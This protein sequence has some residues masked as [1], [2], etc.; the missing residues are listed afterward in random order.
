MRKFAK[1]LLG[2]A[3]LVGTMSSANA[4]IILNTDIANFQQKVV[5]DINRGLEY[6]KSTEMYNAIDQAR[7]IDTQSKVDAF[8]NGAANWIARVQQQA[9]DVFNLQKEEDTKPLQNACE[10]FSV[11]GAAADALCEEGGIID[12]VA[13]QLGIVSTSSL[14]TFQKAKDAVSSL[15]PGSIMADSPV[16]GANAKNVTETKKAL[17]KFIAEEIAA[18]DKRKAWDQAGKGD[19]ANDP[20]L[21]LVTSSIAPSYEPEELEMALNMARL[22]YPPYVKK[23]YTDPTNVREVAL[24]MREKL[25]REVPNSVIARQIA[26]RTTLDPEKPS[27]LMALGLPVTLMFDEKG[28]ISTE[29]ESWI[30]R[31]ALNNNTTPGEVSKEAL[32][33]KGLQV[34][35]AIET[36]K[37]Q[38]V[39]ERMILN[40]YL[41]RFDKKAEKEG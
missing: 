40:I 31:I 34:N 15:V 25:A 32:L 1:G 14:E 9:A 39:K 24:D 28:E 18:V 38:L 30:H 33:M 23:A 2:I 5:A 37:S 16:S 4:F 6:L 19:Q 27:K 26:M 36:Y 17:D 22:T 8:N 21:L 12:A 35:Q 10:T 11:Q 13:E 29:G 41:S 7:N 20:S 3:I